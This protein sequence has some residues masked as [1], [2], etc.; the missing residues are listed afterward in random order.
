[1]FDPPKLNGPFLKFYLKTYG[2]GGYP[3]DTCTI[4]ILNK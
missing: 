2:D 1:M 4:F 3:D